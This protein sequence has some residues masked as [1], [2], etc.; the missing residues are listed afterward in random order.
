MS[1]SYELLIF[2]IK[3]VLD[4]AKFGPCLVVI[5]CKIILSL[6]HFHF[7]PL[8]AILFGIV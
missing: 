2:F 5:F 8:C 4:L 6:N 7:F 1:S 3:T